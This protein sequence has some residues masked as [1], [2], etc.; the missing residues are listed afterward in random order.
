MESSKRGKTSIPIQ[1][2]CAEGELQDVP[3]LQRRDKNFD[4]MV[5][6]HGTNGEDGELYKSICLNLL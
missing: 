5:G 6:G 4:C 1:K 3:K 2:L